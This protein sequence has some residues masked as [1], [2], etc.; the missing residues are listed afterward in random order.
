MTSLFLSLLIIGIGIPIGKSIA[1]SIKPHAASWLGVWSRGALI[2]VAFGILAFVTTGQASCEEYDDPLRGSCTSYADNGYN[3]T[4]SKALENGFTSFLRT[5][6]AGTI[7]LLLLKRELKK[8][9][10]GR[11]DF[12]S[13]KLLAIKLAGNKD[14]F[15]DTL[16]ILAVNIAC[17][18]HRDPEWRKD[19]KDINTAV[20]MALDII[21]KNQL[22]VHRD[23][24]MAIFMSAKVSL[25]GK[26]VEGTVFEW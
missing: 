13:E 5:V 17:G 12:G 21:K 20:S 26:D 22:E 18:N 9:G 10:N 14:L 1:E 7:G 25:F 3:W 24:F 6:T 15:R 23:E 16:K 4:A 8:A 11:C 2:S 19:F